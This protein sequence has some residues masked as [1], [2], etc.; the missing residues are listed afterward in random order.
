[1]RDTNTLDPAS[2]CACPLCWCLGL[3][4]SLCLC[5]NVTLF[6]LCSTP[7][8][9]LRRR[10]THEFDGH[11]TRRLVTIKCINEMTHCRVDDEVHGLSR[12]IGSRF[13]DDV[14]ITT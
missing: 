6:C 8:Q 5:L 7:R 12:R 13:E 3:C 2:S 10:R 11:G 9:L 4:L 1:M 14:C